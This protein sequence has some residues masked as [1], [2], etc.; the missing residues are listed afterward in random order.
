MADTAKIK[1]G[2]KLQVKIVRRPTNDAAR[3]TLVRLLSKDPDAS[4]EN[5]NLARIR[6][7]LY[8]PRRRGGRLYSGRMPKLRRIKGEPGE[9]GA[10][11]ATMDVI[12]DLSSVERFIEIN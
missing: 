6:K 9:T 12:R 10:I 7:R 11:V 3:K 2:A 5:K 8:S 1:P 4:T